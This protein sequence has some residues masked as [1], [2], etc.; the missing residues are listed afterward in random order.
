MSKFFSRLRQNLI[1]DGKYTR[2]FKNATGEILLLVIGILIAL[3]INN[4]N[5]DSKVDKSIT[6]HLAIL[7]NNLQEDQTHLRQL[8]QTMTDNVHY[9]DSLMK[10][11]KTLIPVDNKTTKYLGKLLLEYQFRPNENAIE[12]ISQ[13][14]EIPF[15]KPRL[16]T[17]ILDYYALI[18]RVKERENI[19]NT[20]IQSKYEVFINSQYPIVFQK[21]N[22]WAFVKDY[23]QDDPRP[24]ISMNVKA[25]LSDKRMEA[26][27][28][29]RYFQSTY[30]KG[31]YNDLLESS[32]TILHL[33]DTERSK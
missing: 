12:T 32:D 26:L 4:W 7:Q 24:L 18:E 13:S 9:A 11:M 17:A 3:Q 1:S 28:T 15:L 29:S 23:Y 14:N 5:E 33:L 6:K 30:L 10:Q 21:N 19:S 27:I 16:Q 31:F 8:Q 20:Q 25:F 22:E 2:Y